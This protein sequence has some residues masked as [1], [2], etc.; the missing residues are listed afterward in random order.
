[1]NKNWTTNA[2]AIGWVLLSTGI[3]S[4]IFASGKFAGDSVE[5]FQI[6]FLRMIGGFIGLSL[7]VLWQGG[8]IAQYRTRKPGTH[9]LRA[10]LGTSGSL[11]AIQ[12]QA[13]M[14][15]VDATALSLLYVVFVLILG[16]VFFH[17]RIGRRQWGGI[18]F[19]CAGAFVIVG[20]RGAFHHF[21]ANYALPASFAVGAALVFAF[22]GMLIKHLSGHDK[23]MVLLL[24]VSVF[25][26]LLLA[27]PAW[28]AWK[29][30]SLTETLIFLALGP[31]GVFAQYCTIRGYSIADISIVGPV[32]YS[33]LIFSSLIG[34]F[35]FNE[36]PTWAVGRGGRPIA[37][38][39]HGRPPGN[40]P[41]EHHPAPEVE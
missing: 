9:F 14:P 17:E 8:K 31:I 18:L 37:G 10:A 32:D 5:V 19:C 11:M 28:F 26:M 23:P 20:S 1:V 22:E 30:L 38:R 34:F 24:H 2:E 13:D 41:P 6:N 36:I 15:I 40:P 29:P 21:D 3:F 39:C 12:S 27:I 25:G 33:W 16:M 7:I 35:F 4:L